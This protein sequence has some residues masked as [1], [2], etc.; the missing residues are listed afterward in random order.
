M[1][2]RCRAA[3]SCRLPPR[4]SRWRSVRPELTGTGATRRAWQSKPAERNRATPA[5]SA[6]SSAAVSGPQRGR[7]SSDYEFGR[8]VV[9][10]RQETRDL[11]VLPTGWCGTGG[12]RKAKR[13]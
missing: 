13:W 4:D 1:A 7:L 2:I 12:A 8:I 6:I 10:G 9:D 5:V 11:I 3:F